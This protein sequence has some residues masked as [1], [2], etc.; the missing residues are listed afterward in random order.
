[1]VPGVGHLNGLPGVLQP[2]LD[3]L[4]PVDCHVFYMVGSSSRVS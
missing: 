4:Q 3:P 1:L 2:A